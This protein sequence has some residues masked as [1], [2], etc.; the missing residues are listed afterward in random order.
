MNKAEQILNEIKPILEFYANSKIGEEQVDGTYKIML[1]GG[2]V[3]A[4]DPTPARQ[5]LQKISEVEDET[6]NN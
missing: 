3:M 2:Y 4:Y 1:S 6:I 5:A